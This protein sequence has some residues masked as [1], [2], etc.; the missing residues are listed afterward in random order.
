M[1]RLLLLPVLALSLALGLPAA[2]ADDGQ[3][4]VTLSTS[5]ESKPTR[6]FEA[7]V[8]KIYAVWLGKG[9]LKAGDKLRAV[10][11][12]E[13][14]GGAAPANYKLDEW[15]GTVEK[16][17]ANGYSSVSKPTAGW[18]E[19]RYR[20]EV[21]VGD[22]RAMTRHFTIGKPGSPAKADKP[23]GKVEDDEDDE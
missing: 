6:Q 14:T 20:V 21:H 17:G 18:P 4:P 22:K 7:D 15:N 3:L 2:S 23:K 10:W 9:V 8:A 13:D 19:G 5:P 12:A 1:M 11:I 16:D